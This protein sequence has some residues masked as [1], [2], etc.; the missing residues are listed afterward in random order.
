MRRPAALLALAALLAPASA[1]A[2][3]GGGIGDLLYPA[4]NLA[5][6]LAVLWFLARKPIVAWFDARREA[7]RGELE[8]AGKLRKEAEERHARWQR[9]LVDLDSELE[10]IRRT[11]RERAEAER[12]R[13]LADARAGAERIRNDAR[14]A[15]EQEVRRAREQLRREAADLSV[16]LAGEMLR[17]R[18]TDADRARL[19]D[20][21]IA[22]IERPAADGRG[23]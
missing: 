12:E 9:Q 1:R 2:A 6:L 4:L 3:G 14:T 11:A 20:E 13:I 7:I 23:R 18:V 15:V 5:L 8:A 19:L 16:E 22:T 21:F 10:G 17:T